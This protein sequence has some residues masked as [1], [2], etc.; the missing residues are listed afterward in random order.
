MA[1]LRADRIDSGVLLLILDRPSARNALDPELTDALA[2]ALAQFANDTD[3]VV[4]VLTGSDPAFCAG[5]DMHAYGDATADRSRVSA[6]LRAV[7]ESPKPLI[8][9]V[10]GPAVTGGLELAL[11]CDWIVASERAVF[12][13]THSRI[14]AF[15]GSGL[16]AR[17]PAAVGVRMAKAISLAGYRLDAAGAVRTGLAVSAVPHDDLL[18]KAIEMAREVAA[19]NP[20]LVRAIRSTYD[21]AVGVPTAT[22]LA[23]EAAARAAWRSGPGADLS[24]PEPP[25]QGRGSHARPA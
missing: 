2:D 15:P 1:A 24:W 10:N 4:G 9:A 25:Q 20:A 22:A 13:D 6:V 3:L 16:S 14:G 23:A 5:L 12:A 18:P 19:R 21:E 11:A 17:L 8:A 7:G